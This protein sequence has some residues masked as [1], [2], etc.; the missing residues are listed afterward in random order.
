MREICTSGSMSGMWKQSHGRASEAPPNERG[1][2]RYVRPT[3]TAPHLDS[4]ESRPPTGC[5]ASDLH[6]YLFASPGHD[7]IDL[8]AAAFGADQPLAPIGHGRLGA[9]PSSHLGGIGLDLMAAIAAPNDETNAGRG[10]ASERSGRP[11]L[12]F[13]LTPPSG[14]RSSR[15]LV[16]LQRRQWLAHRL[17]SDLGE[18]RLQGLNARRQRITIA[19]YGVGQ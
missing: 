10:R 14:R 6:D 4:T 11:W 18:D 12:G 9:V 7:H 8:T 17:R 2:N 19:I 13:Q 16:M 3:A 5:Q 15:R 1:G